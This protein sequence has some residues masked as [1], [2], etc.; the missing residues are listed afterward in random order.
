MTKERFEDTYGVRLV[1]KKDDLLMKLIG[2]LL[3]VFGVDF[4]RFF[5]TYRLPFQKRATIAYPP[6]IC[7]IMR[8]RDVLEHELYHVKQFSP[9][10]GP[11]VVFLLVTII[12]LPVFFS[13]RWFVER[14]PYLNDIKNRRYSIEAAVNTLWA[15]YF[16]CWPRFLMRKWFKKQLNIV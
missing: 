13:G 9:W 4:E 6:N 8:F 15:Y 7:D 5:T 10:Y 11:L 16:C 1:S 3:M 12:P 14:E 2:I